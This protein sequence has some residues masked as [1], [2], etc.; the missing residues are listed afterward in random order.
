MGVE[1]AVNLI[2]CTLKRPSFQTTPE[3]QK[4]MENLFMA[5]QVQAALMEKS[6]RPRSQWRT[7]NWWSL[8]AAP[9]TGKEV[10]R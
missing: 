2:A 9:G 6:P 3:S 7:G 5:A 1:D 10:N 4:A 8:S